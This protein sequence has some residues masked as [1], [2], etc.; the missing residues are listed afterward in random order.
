P[1][2]AGSTLAE[3]E[4]A[5]AD[6]AIDDLVERVHAYLTDVKTTQIRMGLHTLG[7]PP[8]DDRLVEYLVALTRLEN[9]G[10]PSLRES[11]AGV[12]GVDY[13]QMRERPGAY[14]ENLGMTYAEA[15]DRVHEV[16]CDLVATLAERGFDV[17]ESE[18]EAG[19]DDEV[20]MNL[21]VVDV[22][23]IGDARARSGAHDDLRE[24]L[25][26]ICE[27][28]APRVGGARA[29][30]GNVADALAGEYVPPGG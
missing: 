2:E 6:L 14:D 30:V 15:A 20:N 22:D 25:A 9:P 7:E 3:G 1:D 23:T 13:D 4:V 17:P 28:A 11:V 21:L 29:E 27:E 12:L 24:A 19:P 10:A 18:R 8:A 16:S 5:G 26:Y